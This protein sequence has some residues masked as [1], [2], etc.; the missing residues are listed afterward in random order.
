MSYCFSSYLITKT[1]DMNNIHPAD[2]IAVQQNY[3]NGWQRRC[4]EY[5]GIENGYSKLKDGENTIRVKEAYMEEINEPKFKVGESVYVPRKKSN[6]EVK[7]IHYHMKKS[8]PIYT[9]V[10]SGAESGYQYFDEDLE[11]TV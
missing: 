9:I 10:V 2:R 8:K 11:K 6:G 7:R 3:C 1:G 5:L 4:F